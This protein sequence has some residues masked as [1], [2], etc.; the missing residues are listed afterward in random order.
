M[1]ERLENVNIN[2]E[3]LKD[4][5]NVS[6]S[7]IKDLKDEIKTDKKAIAELKK[8]RRLLMKQEKKETKMAKIKA[9]KKE[10]VYAEELSLDTVL[11]M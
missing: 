9:K 10:T 5:I 11:E 6:K 1:T 8:K 3:T 2:I 4:D 7:S